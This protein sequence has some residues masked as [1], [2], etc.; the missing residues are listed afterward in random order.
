MGRVCATPCASRRDC[1]LGQP[2]S[3]TPIDEDGD[4]FGDFVLGAC[5]T[6]LPGGRFLAGRC[7]S[8][9]DCESRSCVERQCAEMCESAELDCLPGHACVEQVLDDVVEGSFSGCGFE[10]RVGAHE[11]EDVLVDVLPLTASGLD[12]RVNVAV[13]NDTQSVTF[14]ATHVSGDSVP[15][16]YRTVVSP[17][18]SLLFDLEELGMWVD[19]PIRWIPNSNEEAATLSVPSSTPDRVRVIGGR[20]SV[21]VMLLG[22]GPG[23]ARSSEIELSM[24][25]VRANRI[26]RGTIDLD[27][28]PVGVGFTAADA[29]MDARLSNALSNLR[30]IWDAAGLTLG[31][32]TFRDVPRGTVSRLSVIES[33]DG[34]GSELAQL[35]RLSSEAT[36]AALPIF[37]VRSIDATRDGGVALG[38]AGGIPG[39]PL[40]YGTMHSGVVVTYDP[41][42]IGSGSRGERNI[43]QVI[44]HE[45]GH[46]LGLYHNRERLDPCP[47][48]TGPTMADP[49]APFGGE[50]VIADTTRRDGDNL[51]WWA[52]GGDTG[53]R[54]NVTL[55]EGQAFVLLRSPLVRR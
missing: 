4:G 27:I 23:D 32:V 6:P 40:L 53:R 13:P 39:P 35:F 54:Y 51:M 42:V 55:T 17:N 9:D 24:R 8:A 10:P 1:E 22:D 52:L 25:V 50:D 28:Y 18:E 7:N 49:C 45:S 2:C 48:G 3:P 29:P 30:D 5:V 20:H 19:Q 15:I 16:A 38:I 47:A 33:T 11:V 26:P 44:A 43:A 31:T 21:R 14:V 12:T 34:P 36:P 41:A 46:F 37:L